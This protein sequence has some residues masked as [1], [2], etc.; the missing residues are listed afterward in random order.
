MS[1]G[2]RRR[3]ETLRTIAAGTSARTRRR[4]FA[5]VD[6]ELQEL[7][8]LRRVTPEKRRHLL[9][10]MHAMRALETALKEMAG[11]HGLPPQRSI[12][13]VLHQLAQLPPN[14]ASHL[15]QRS[16]SRFM[17]SVRKDRNRY[18]HNA[19]AFPRT[20]READRILGEIAACF[21]LIVK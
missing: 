8:S 4:G 7:S 5:D 17:N 9:E 3:F 19:N 1:A 15:D 16:F 20:A 18:M 6:Q 11:S 14:H 10:I 2:Q 21:A 12:G 13:S